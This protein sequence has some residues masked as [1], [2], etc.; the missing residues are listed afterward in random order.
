MRDADVLDEGPVA[1]EQLR[2]AGKRWDGRDLEPEQWLDGEIDGSFAGT[3]ERH[4][5][6][7][8]D[9]SEHVPLFDVLLYAEAEGAIFRAGTL[10]LVGAYS[11]GAVE[12]RDARA[13]AAV[14]HVLRGHR[15]VE[16]VP[17]ETARPR[18][19]RAK[20]KAARSARRVVKLSAR[21]CVRHGTKSDGPA[22]RATSR[23]VSRAVRQKHGKGP[24]S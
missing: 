5:L 10:E 6:V 21:E 22:V 2:I 20:V 14:E 9:A 23:A 13:R 8:A 1:E 12:M 18:P 24:R 11:D 7:D 19:I 4:V 15:S 16:T 17:I 3:L